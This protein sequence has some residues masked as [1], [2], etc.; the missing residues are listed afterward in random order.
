MSRATIAFGAPSRRAIASM[1]RR[2]A[3]CGTNAAS[4]AGLD[5][6]ALA[7][8]ERD[9][10]HLRGGPA[11][12][13]LA[14]LP[15]GA[16]RARRWRRRR[17]ARRRCP[18]RPGRC[19][20]RRT[21]PTTAAP[22][23]SARM[24]QVVRSVKSSQPE[25]RSAPTTSTL[26]AWPGCTAADAAFERVDEAGAAGV[27]VEGARCV[28][29]EPG[30]ELRRGG[31]HRRGHR[32]GGD[33]HEVDVGRRRRRW[34]PAPCCAA[35]SAMSTTVSSGSAQRRS[36]MPT[37]LRIHSSSVSTPRAIRSALVTTFAGR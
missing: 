25:N 11:V 13:R 27:D 8:L 29:A 26:R 30:G 32:A 35:A 21:A 23:P 34:R 10:R 4:S 20:R 33:E 9:R 24:M 31:G 1:M 28:D 15:E 17:T 7:G 22:A 37:R 36:A 19:P 18:T 12:D 16:G 14:L 2:L 6:G 5:A 3:W